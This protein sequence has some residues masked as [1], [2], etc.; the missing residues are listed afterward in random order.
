MKKLWR[1]LTAR[2]GGNAP[3]RAVI[4]ST[5]DMRIDYYE[6]SLRAA[7]HFREHC[8]S[9]WIDAKTIDLTINHTGEEQ[10][11]TVIMDDTGKFFMQDVFCFAFARENYFKDQL[12]KEREELY[13]ELR[14]GSIVNPAGDLVPGDR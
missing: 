7:A 9:A 4:S 10:R 2:D 14:G 1:W 13:R 3:A 8:Y 5:R 12:L 11:V 6:K